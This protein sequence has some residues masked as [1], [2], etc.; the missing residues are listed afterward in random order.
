MD[1]IRII[2][3]ASKVLFGIVLLMLSIEG[4][5]LVITGDPLLLHSG[6]QMLGMALLFIV[7]FFTGTLD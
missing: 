7:T 5:S 3:T 2:G 4:I 6:G 1:I